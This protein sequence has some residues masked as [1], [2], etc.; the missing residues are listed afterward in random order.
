MVR[1][2]GGRGGGGGVGEC[3]RSFFLA[4]DFGFVIL[5]PVLLILPFSSGLS[6]WLSGW[7][8]ASVSLPA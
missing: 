4:F 6:S 8:W 7:G 2:G 1:T 3:A 5:F